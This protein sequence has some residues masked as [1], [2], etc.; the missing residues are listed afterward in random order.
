MHQSLYIVQKKQGVS[1]LPH[2]RKLI[3]NI[4]QRHAYV[5]VFPEPS[6]FEYFQMVLSSDCLRQNTN[7]RPK[8]RTKQ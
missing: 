1:R 6:P 5:T 7:V 2:T 8:L 4:S 3:F